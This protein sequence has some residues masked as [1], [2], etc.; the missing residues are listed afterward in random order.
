M[1][2]DLIDSSYLMQLCFEQHGTRATR[3]RTLRY[4]RFCLTRNNIGI[5]FNSFVVAVDVVISL[6]DSVYCRSLASLTVF[7]FRYYMAVHYI[8]IGR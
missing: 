7:F 3:Q 1:V 2:A 6:A 8:A 4:F 5:F